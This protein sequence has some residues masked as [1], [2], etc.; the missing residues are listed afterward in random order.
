M[1]T[2]ANDPRVQVNAVVRYSA[3]VLCSREHL[4]GG[5]HFPLAKHLCYSPRES[6]V[7]WW[8]DI[9]V[10][11]FSCERCYGRMGCAC[12]VRSGPKLCLLRSGLQLN[13][14]SQQKDRDTLDAWLILRGWC[15]C[16]RLWW[17]TSMPTQPSMTWQASSGSMQLP[18]ISASKRSSA[19]R[20][21]WDMLCLA[22]QSKDSI[23]WT[24]QMWFCATLLHSSIE[25]WDLRSNQAETGSTE[26][27]KATHHQFKKHLT[28][29]EFV[30]LWLASSWSYIQENIFWCGARHKFSW[31]PKLRGVL[32]L[33]G[34]GHW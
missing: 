10:E 6:R 33:T 25:F 8:S 2:L 18:R 20:L 13:L 1:T 3:A 28:L 4:F 23:Y 34:H 30:M 19:N 5:K 24:F 29:P 7:C 12:F 26:L 14:H 32:Y 21:R 15:L 9:L 16:R 17:R 22:L 31:N 11:I 27:G